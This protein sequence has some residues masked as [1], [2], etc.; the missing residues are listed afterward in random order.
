M[1]ENKGTE[2]EN[3][4]IISINAEKIFD[5]MQHPYMIKYNCLKTKNR[6]DLFKFD[7]EHL[8]KHARLTSHSVGERLCLL[9]S[10]GA[11]PTLHRV[12]VGGSCWCHEAGE[13]SKG[14]RD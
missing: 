12:G 8:P 1:G 4:V 7:K 10:A 2:R 14:H 13:A 9:S 5:K 3:H 11:A 6:G